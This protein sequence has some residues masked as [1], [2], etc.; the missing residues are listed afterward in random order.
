MRELGI[1]SVNTLS[2]DQTADF[3]FKDRHGR[4]VRDVDILA[5]SENTDDAFDDENM[6]MDIEADVEIPGVDIVE[7]PRVDTDMTPQVDDLDIPAPVPPSVL[8]A[9]APLEPTPVAVESATDAPAMSSSFEQ[10]IEAQAGSRRSTRIMSK[11]KPYIPSMP[12]S[13]YSYAVTQLENEG[14][15]NPD[16]HMFVQEEFYQSEADVVAATM[17]QLSLKNGLKER[18]GKH[19]RPSS[20]R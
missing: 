14:L 20:P 16:A 5:T 3:L 17:T 6:G 2:N 1:A 11:S 13:K 18:G 4:L 19:T 8:E 7:L 10:L 15:L 9:I 12:G